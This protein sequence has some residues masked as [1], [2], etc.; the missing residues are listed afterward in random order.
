MVL[1]PRYCFSLD[2][3]AHAGGRNADHGLRVANSGAS[4]AVGE[5]VGGG[6]NPSPRLVVWGLELVWRGWLLFRASTR[7]RPKASAD[8]EETV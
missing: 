4:R 2:N 3:V 1:G 8:S 6:V 7:W 5:G